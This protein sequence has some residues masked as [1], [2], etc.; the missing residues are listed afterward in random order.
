MHM[1]KIV[2]DTDWWREYV[3]ERSQA[4]E[5]WSNAL[6]AVRA[7]GERH[8]AELEAW[9][10]H[11]SEA[12]RAGVPLAERRPSPDDEWRDLARLESQAHVRVLD[13]QRR[14]AQVL[15]KHAEEVYKALLKQATAGARVIEAALRALV[16]EHGDVLADTLVAL[17]TARAVSAAVKGEAGRR[18][19]SELLADGGYVPLDEPPKWTTPADI[20]TAV[21]A[22]ALT[23]SPEPVPA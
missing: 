3:D 5:E 19:A 16:D 21:L 15:A 17:E 4:Q 13:V 11:L 1:H 14:G 18:P 6:A 12:S 20:V 9:K 8:T 23:R 7:V 22:G 2:A 10:T